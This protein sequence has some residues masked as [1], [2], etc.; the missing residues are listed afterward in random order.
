MERKSLVLDLG[1]ALD[2]PSLSARLCSARVCMCMWHARDCSDTILIITPDPPPTYICVL[3][4][5]AW[6]RLM[7]T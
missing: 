6:L 4:C 2:P 3:R 1:Y 7:P 5:G